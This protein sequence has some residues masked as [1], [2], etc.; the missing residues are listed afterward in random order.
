MEPFDKIHNTLTKIALLELGKESSGYTSGEIMDS[1]LIER[2]TFFIL[3][4]KQLADTSGKL[5][6]WDGQRNAS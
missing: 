2:K 1:F 3:F 5:K 4:S 6:E